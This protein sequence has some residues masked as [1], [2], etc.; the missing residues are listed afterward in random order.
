M[1]TSSLFTIA[2]ATLLPLAGA[3]DSAS[4]NELELEQLDQ[5]DQLD[6]LL[7]P[8]RAEFELPALSG[9][10]LVDGKLWGLGAVGLRRADRDVPV[11]SADLWHLGSC[12][13]SMTAT[14]I[15]LLV[16]RGE[17]EWETTIGDVYPELIESESM[18]PD[19][20]DVPIEWLLQNRSGAPHDLKADGL[21]TRLRIHKGTPI[22]QRRAL[23]E[24]VLARAPE[25]PPGT[26][27]IYSNAGFSIA[28]AM[29]ETLVGISWEAG[30]TR[31]LFDPLGMSSFSFGLPGLPGKVVQP[32]GHRERR[33]KLLA[34]PPVPFADNPS[35]IAPAGKAH[36]SLTDWAAYAALH[37]AGARGEKDLLL[38]P[39]TF[40]RMHEPHNGYAM[41]WLSTEWD[42]TRAL[43]HNGS[44]GMWYCEI[45]IVPESNCAVLAASNRGDGRVRKALPR[46][47]ELLYAH[48]QK[49]R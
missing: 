35:A 9:A 15:A 6:V 36:G 39:S 18:H 38:E 43:W 4:S 41:G 30:I 21:W 40:A 29:A 20:A 33:G 8:L 32:F 46:V 31:D 42:G 28:G 12:T 10:I 1:R 5:L 23:V 14:W 34:M 25:A 47:L 49:A 17:L 27:Y 22:E 37:L 48:A 16:E 26:E 45:L 24:G 11:S 7:E 13:K 19:W 3:Q 2:L 44:N